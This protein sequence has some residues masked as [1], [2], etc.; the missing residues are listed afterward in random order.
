VP[1]VHGIEDALMNMRILDALHRSE[2]SAG[3]EVIRSNSEIEAPAA[4]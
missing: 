3:W 2:I 4:P 1:H